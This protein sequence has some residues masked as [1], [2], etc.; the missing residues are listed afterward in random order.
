MN[1]TRC[2]VDVA[3]TLLIHRHGNMSFAI[4]APTRA[5]FHTR[6]KSR[7]SP[8]TRV[9]CTAGLF[10]GFG[11]GGSKKAKDDVLRLA[12]TQRRGVGHSPE[13]RAE[14]EAAVDAL[15][16]SRGK[17]GRANTDRNVLTADW[18]LAWTSENETL[19][20]LEKFPGGVDGAPLTQAYQRIDVDEGTLSNEVVFCNGTD[21]VVNSVIEVVDDVRVSFQFTAA[22]LNL[23]EPVEASVPLP[24]FGRG[25]FD[26]V[27]VDKDMR[28]AR[29]SR[30][31]TLVVVRD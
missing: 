22:A 13:D 4:A 18:R 30:G 11:R 31:D 2:C 20:L 19:F 17:G 26:N 1:K 5:T 12:E 3:F 7:A 21:F 6:V 28:V 23:A 29:D 16:A 9:G 8:R 10:D 24:P 15:I 25:W 27:Y 14:M